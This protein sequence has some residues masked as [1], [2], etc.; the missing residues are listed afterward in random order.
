MEKIFI[1]GASGCVGH[2]L[3]DALIHNPNYQLNLLV[4]DLNKLKFN[5]YDFPNVTI[6]H[7]D[8]K[9]IEKHAALLKEIDYVIHLAADWGGNEGNYDYTLGLFKLL[10]HNKCK[11]VIYFSTASILGADNKPV[12]AAEI[13]G[14]HYIRSKYRAY[15]ELPGLKIYPKVITLFPTWVLGGDETHPFSHASLGIIGL[16][17]WLWLIRFIAVDASFHFIHAKDIALITKH[18]LE[19]DVKEKE[20]ILGNAPVTA[21]EFIKETCHLFGLRVYFQILIPQSF[22]RILAFLTGRKLQP[23]DLYCFNRRHFT[24]DTVNAETFG[25]KFG[26]KTIRDALPSLARRH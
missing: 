23:W 10:D 14:T 6:V 24:Y 8:L 2:Y 22:V 25:L 16:R 4:R 1:T 9:N 13:F 20:F 17:G 11:R 21:R 3:F 7:D 12:E 15:K 19:N 26:L 5:P 18:L